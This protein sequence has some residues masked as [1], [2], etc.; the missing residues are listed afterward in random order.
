[1]TPIGFPHS[2]IPGSKLV[3][4]SPRLIAACHVLHRL[5]A[6]RHPPYTLSSLTK[7]STS[8][9]SYR[10]GSIQLSKSSKQHRVLA[11]TSGRVTFATRSQMIKI[12]DPLLGSHIMI[13]FQFVRRSSPR[14]VELI[15]F[16]PTTPA[17]QGRRSP[18]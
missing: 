8:N 5:S 7:L 3:C 4:S 11:S 6:P 2:E 15:G 9:E 13:I 14:M 1:M 16:E 18:S 12:Y 10:L 17:V